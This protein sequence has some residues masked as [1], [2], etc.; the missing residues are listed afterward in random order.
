MLYVIIQYDIIIRMRN[1][2]NKLCVPWRWLVHDFQYALA[3][4]TKQATATTYL[5]FGKLNDLEFDES[6]NSVR[7][8]SAVVLL[9]LFRV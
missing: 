6:F 9:P 1:L 2:P 5:N 8:I 7:A 4:R 3:V